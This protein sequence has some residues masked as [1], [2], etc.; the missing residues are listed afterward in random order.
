MER[1]RS[2]AE[3]QSVKS[4]GAKAELTSG[5]FFERLQGQMDQQVSS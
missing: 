5:R 2:I 3:E 1:Q 4:G